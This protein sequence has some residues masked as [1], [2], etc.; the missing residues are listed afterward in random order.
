[1]KTDWLAVAQDI[2]ECARKKVAQDQ[3]KLEKILQRTAL[4]AAEQV[5]AASR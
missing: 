3:E 1:M 4:R 2:T 5:P